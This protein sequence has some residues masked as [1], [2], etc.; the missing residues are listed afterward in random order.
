MFNIFFFT[1]TCT[2]GTASSQHPTIPVTEGRVFISPTVFLPDLPQD[3]PEAALNVTPVSHLS[4]P[5]H[6]KGKQ[7]L[8]ILK[9]HVGTEYGK[10]ILQI[11]LYVHNSSRI[12]PDSS[13]IS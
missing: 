9:L 1:A 3:L 8:H 6:G 2:F 7:P 12:Q 13:G 4:T 10:P 11:Y 5:K